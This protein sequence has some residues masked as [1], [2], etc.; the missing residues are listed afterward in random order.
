MGA[1]RSLR[2]ARIRRRGALLRVL[3]GMIATARLPGQK[4]VR[5]AKH[6]WT[7]AKE[8][9]RG[10]GSR[11]PHAPPTLTPTSSRAWA[12]PD[13][14]LE[15]SFAADSTTGLVAGPA[16]E[17]ASIP[18][19]RSEERVVGLSEIVHLVESFAR[20]PQF[21]DDSPHRSPTRSIGPWDL[22]VPSS[23]S[24]PSNFA[25]TMRAPRSQAPLR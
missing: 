9:G 6:R 13:S 17:H 23:S 14:Y 2:G 25:L 24:R 1:G 12:R 15:V 7:A 11:L 16:A 22:A 8:P 18:T 10:E 4:D 5:R 20:R 21:Q 3:C 19:S